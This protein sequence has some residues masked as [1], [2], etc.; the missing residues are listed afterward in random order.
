MS[1]GNTGPETGTT[2]ASCLQLPVHQLLGVLIILDPHKSVPLLKVFQ[3]VL[4]HLPGQ[5]FPSVETDLYVEG[6]PGLKP[7]VHPPQ[8]GMNLILIQHVRRP[9]S[10][11]V[12]RRSMFE[13][14]ARLQTANRTRPSAG[15]GVIDS[16]LRRGAA[17]MPA[18]RPWLSLQAITSS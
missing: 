10:P 13:D 15:G 4:I 12:V 16:R 5:P 17:V 6:K 14:G 8:L 1:K 11:D 18:L 3:P 9:L 7:R 2:K